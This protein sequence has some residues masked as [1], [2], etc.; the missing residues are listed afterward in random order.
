MKLLAL[1]C[2]RGL[3]VCIRQVV[4]L[5]FGVFFKLKGFK[6]CLMNGFY[7]GNSNIALH[8]IAGKVDV[9]S[10]RRVLV[11]LGFSSFV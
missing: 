9:K 1:F 7:T 2:L 10:L 6:R 11:N 4:F 3:T 8:L 5:C